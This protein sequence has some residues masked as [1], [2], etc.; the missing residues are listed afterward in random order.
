MG[1][2]VGGGTRRTVLMGNVIADT[3]PGAAK[4]LE[5]GL[6][7]RGCNDGFACYNHVSGCKDADIEGQGVGT[8]YLNEKNG[9]DWEGATRGQR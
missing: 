9:D 3:R 5:Y 4:R 6:L 1:I 8:N 2:I 7:L